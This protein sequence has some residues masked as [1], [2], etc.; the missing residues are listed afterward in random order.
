MTALIQPP[1]DSQRDLPKDCE[2]AD[3]AFAGHAANRGLRDDH[4][5]AEGQR[6][7]EYRSAEK[8]PP[9]YLAARYGK[10]QMLPSPTEAPA[11]EST[12]PILPENVLRA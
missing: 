2:C 8:M 4:R 1:A 9:P 10:R 7:N 6:Q 5:I 12:N 11:A 3:R